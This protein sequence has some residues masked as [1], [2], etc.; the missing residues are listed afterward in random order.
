MGF[1]SSSPGVASDCSTDMPVK[2]PTQYNN[3][4]HISLV[5]VAAVYPQDTCKDTVGQH[6][7]VNHARSAYSDG[8]NAKTNRLAQQFAV[9]FVR[10]VATYLEDANKIVCKHVGPC[11]CCE[12]EALNHAVAV[13]SEQLH[14]LREEE[15]HLHHTQDLQ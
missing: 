1:I 6:Q 12:Q 9:I 5:H 7:R 13:P 8:C 10:C 4:K 3:A 2:Q 14:Q 15:C 11:C